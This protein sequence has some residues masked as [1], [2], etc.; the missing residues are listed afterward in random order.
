M[1]CKMFQCVVES[2]H[3]NHSTKWSEGNTGVKPISQLRRLALTFSPRRVHVIDKVATI[4]HS[5]T[6]CFIF[7]PIQ[8]G[9]LKGS[10]TS[11]SLVISTN[12]GISP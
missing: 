12:V 9:W 7:N 3:N 11:F 1:K 8:A 6:F 5:F 10:P 4:A 2:T